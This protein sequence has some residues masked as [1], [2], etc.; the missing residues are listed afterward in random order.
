MGLLGITVT[1]AFGG[2]D[3]GYLAHVL[4]MEEISRASAPFG[5]QLWCIVTS[6]LTRSFATAPRISVRPVCRN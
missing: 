1:E 6:V 5:P 3:L 2:A 4:A